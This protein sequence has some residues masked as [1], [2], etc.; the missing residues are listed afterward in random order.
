MD[1]CAHMTSYVMQEWRRYER[2]LFHRPA[3]A[4]A[5]LLGIGATLCH[6]M[7]DASVSYTRHV[8]DGILNA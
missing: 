4:L 5:K 1:F 8:F 2:V 3:L 7:K 6:C